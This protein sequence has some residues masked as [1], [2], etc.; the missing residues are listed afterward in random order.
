MDGRWMLEEGDFDIM[1][2][3]QTLPIHCVESYIWNSPNIP[4]E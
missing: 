1:V 2:G 4:E 3:D